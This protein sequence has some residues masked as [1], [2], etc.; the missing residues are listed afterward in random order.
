MEVKYKILDTN[1]LLTDPNKA[2]NYSFRP[3][4]G[5]I[6]YLILPIVVI[7]E[8]DKFKHEDT[9]RGRNAREA[10][11]LLKKIKQ[12]SPDSSYSKG[13]QLADNYFIR[14]VT[15]LEQDIEKCFRKADE[16][17][18]R[19]FPSK[20]ANISLDNR[21][22]SIS[23]AYQRQYADTKTLKK[24]STLA[25]VELVTQ[26]TNLAIKA[27]A[28][29]VAA[30]DW[31]DVRAIKNEQEFYK[32]YNDDIILDGAMYDELVS[33][34]FAK[35]RTLVTLKQLNRESCFPNEFFKIETNDENYFGH[36]L[37]AKNNPF[38][39]EIH[40]F[41]IC[42]GDKGI[43]RPDK[44][45]YSFK[46]IKPRNY[47]QAF[48]MEALIDERIKLVH[49][50]GRAG[51]GK[52]LC[53]LAAALQLH[54]KNPNLNLLV[55][56]PIIS[57]GPTLGSLPGDKDEKLLP[58]MDPIADNLSVLGQNLESLMNAGTITLQSLEHIRGRSINAFYMVE[59]AQNLTALEV[60]A[61]I[62]RMA[63]NS[64]AD[65]SKIVLTGDPEQI[66]HPYLNAISTGILYS[67]ERVKFKNVSATVYLSIGERGELAT[68]AAELL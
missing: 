42:D 16:D 67:S 28:F 63:N 33:N 10:A 14:V 11:R 4:E 46:F 22:L 8:L 56:K 44:K 3:K 49:L 2:L 24:N 34:V 25:E 26:D 50:I 60:K 17:V 53:A 1:I 58:W 23:L 64:K 20:D 39:G 36:A 68:L 13:I 62:T 7:E 37:L 43:I 65:K 12:K 41:A 40:I 9:G 6:T 18:R 48:A 55:T 57:V 66:D 29:G 15:G 47:Q 5:A 31:E 45:E 19:S 32:G 30:N 61:I 51:T 27:S 21:I 54:E 35:K 38:E 59:E 52:T